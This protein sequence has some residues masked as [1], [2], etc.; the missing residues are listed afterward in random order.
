MRALGPTLG[1]PPFN[2]GSLADPVIAIFEGNGQ[3]IAPNDNWQ[4]TQAIE[5]KATGKAPPNSSESAILITDLLAH[6]PQF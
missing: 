4:D 5:I 6:I 1:Q 3:Q 2:A